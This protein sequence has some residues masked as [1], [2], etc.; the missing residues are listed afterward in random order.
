V[1]APTDRI[2]A[3]PHTLML[4]GVS[5]P[6]EPEVIMMPALGETSAKVN[7]QGIDGHWSPLERIVPE[8]VPPS[9]TSVKQLLNPTTP[10][11]ML[12]GIPS[13]SESA[14]TLTFSVKVAVR[15]TPPPTACIVI[16]VEELGVPDDAVN[17][18]IE[19]QVGLQLAG[20]NPVAVTPLG[21]AVMM[22]K[23]TGVV[24]PDVS[25]AVAVST[26]PAPPA[27]IVRVDGEALRLKSNCA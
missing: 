12:S 6:A 2:D 25:V 15:V 19:L 3:P 20:L 7:W 26:P 13:P 21:K 11:S 24:V 16:A 10:Q 1:F 14:V 9:E 17:V 23:V 8:V 18:T 27:V 4:A 22:L 5:P